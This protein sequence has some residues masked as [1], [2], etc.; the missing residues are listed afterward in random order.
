MTP[1]QMMRAAKCDWPVVMRPNTFKGGGVDR[2][3]KS[4]TLVRE[5]DWAVLS[6]VS[7][8]YKPVQNAEVFDFF[9]KFTASGKMVMETAG[10]L[11]GGKYV[12]ALAKC[13]GDFRLGKNDEVKPYLLIV[14]PH[15]RGAA[16][17]MK[18]TAIRVVCWNTMTMALGASLRHSE[19]GTFRMPHTKRFAEQIKYAEQALGLTTAA[20]DEFKEAAEHL[21]K[22]RVD[23][24]KVYEYFGHLLN[25]TGA[26]LK[27][28]PVMLPKFKDALERAPGQQLATAKGTWWGALNAVTYV[29][30]HDIGKDRQ[31]ALKNAWLANM[32]RLKSRALALALEE[33]K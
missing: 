26:E 33:A 14:S 23:T 30:D 18:Y 11:D 17:V 28:T 4:Y 32:A 8:H 29:I 7:E 22:V 3:A 24:S 21:A 13:K 25:P 19:S 6:T 15:V 10:S 2:D 5:T 12:W 31:T 16:V 1:E 9:K 20:N 27:R